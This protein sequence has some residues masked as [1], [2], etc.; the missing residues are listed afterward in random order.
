MGP[1]VL[2]LFGYWLIQIYLHYL[3]GIQAVKL[4]HFL[5]LCCSWHMAHR[6]FVAEGAGKLPF[7][8]SC[9]AYLQTKSCVSTNR[10]M[11][12][13]NSSYW[14]THKVW[15]GWAGQWKLTFPMKLVLGMQ[16]SL[17]PQ[18][19]NYAPKIGSLP[20]SLRNHHWK[21][22]SKSHSKS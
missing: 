7:A 19:L 8:R 14:L 5:R 17:K 22:Q 4:T 2:N 13:L 15:F 16:P 10:R 6:P 20:H 3:P 1:P 11:S 18:Y 12:S 21:R 9:P